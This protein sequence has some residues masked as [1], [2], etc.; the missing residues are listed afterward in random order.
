MY[1]QNFDFKSLN[2]SP[3]KSLPKQRYT[4]PSR[5]FTTRSQCPTCSLWWWRRR[6]QVPILYDNY[7]HIH[8]GR[9]WGR[10]HSYY[11]CDTNIFTIR[12]NTIYC[13]AVIKRALDLVT[14]M[15][16]MGSQFLRS[17]LIDLLLYTELFSPYFSPHFT[18][19]VLKGPK[20]NRGE[21]FPVDNTISYSHFLYLLMSYCGQGLNF[22][23]QLNM[24]IPT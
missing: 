16:E 19:F 6:C 15:V 21:Y 9:K 22:V 8:R 3:L 7:S 5:L 13:K 14:I 18:L 2:Y 10:A 24:Y 20:L 1:E 11:K 4:E 17:Y 12:T 23:W